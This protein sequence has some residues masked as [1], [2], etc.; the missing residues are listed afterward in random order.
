MWRPDDGAPALGH[1]V[2][3]D[4]APDAERGRTAAE[5]TDIGR[6]DAG[7]ATLSR[8]G[9]GH[10]TGLREGA[11]VTI[12]ILGGPRTGACGQPDPDTLA[13]LRDVYLRVEGDLEDR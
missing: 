2:A 12:L 4:R 9:P 5:R 3:T 13:A 7:P 1:Q 8:S 11:G 10:R 6:T